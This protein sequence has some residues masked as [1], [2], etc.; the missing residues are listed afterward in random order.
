MKVFLKLIG[1]TTTTIEVE[2]EMSVFDFRKKGETIL[3][4]PEG[5]ELQ[6]VFSGKKLSDDEKIKEVE[7]KENSQII[8]FFAKV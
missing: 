1:G 7:I 5:K 2:E 3:N 8:C 4:I 6:L